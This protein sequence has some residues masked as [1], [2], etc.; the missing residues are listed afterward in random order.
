MNLTPEKIREIV[1]KTLETIN[2]V[3]K[4]SHPLIQAETKDGIFNDIDSAIDAANAAQGQFIQLSIE[5]RK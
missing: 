5:K 2:D 1:K 4:D 3:P